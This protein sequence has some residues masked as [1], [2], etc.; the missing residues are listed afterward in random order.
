MDKICD[1]IKERGINMVFVIGGNGGNAGAAALQ[2]KCAEREYPCAVVGV[3][4]SIDNDILVIDKTFGFDTACQEGVKVRSPPPPP[5]SSPPPS[6]SLCGG[7]H[8]QNCWN[9][10][11]L[12]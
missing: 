3:P 10:K 8:H 4:K 1:S 7:N 11:A 6:L 9:F 2:R 5:S 12:T